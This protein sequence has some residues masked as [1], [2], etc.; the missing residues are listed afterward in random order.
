LDHFRYAGVN[1]VLMIAYHYPPVQGSSGIQRTLKFAQ[2]LPEFGWQPIV[3][4]VHPRAYRERNGSSLSEG[5]ETIVVHRTFGLDTTRHLAIHGRYPRLLALPDP[6]VSW[7]LGAVPAGLRLIRKYRPQV[8]WSTYP[9]ATA[10]V[11]GLT[12]ARLTRI[13]WIA[14][15]RDPMTDIDYPPDPT[16][17]M[18]YQ[19][20]ERRTVDRSR[21]S[22]CTTPSAIQMYRI[23]YPEVPAARFHVIPN[24]YDETEFK[25]VEQ[26]AITGN[27]EDRGVKPL[28][29]VHSGTLYPSERD[30]RQLFAALSELLEQGKICGDSLRIVL[31]ATGHDGYLRALIDE[32]RIG[33]VVMLAPPIP[34]SR[35]LLEMLRA[36][37]LL[38]LQAS[39]CNQQVPAKLYEYLRTRRPILALTDPEGDT[40]GVLRAAGIDTIARLDSK[41]A[42][43]KALMRFVTLL[44]SKQ[45]P[46]VETNQL[47]NYSRKA[48]T[49]ELAALFEDIRNAESYQT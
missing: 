31:R 48:R 12:L 49:A 16:T 19:W 9:V 28:V 20:I 42:I 23:K 13:P 34:Y 2:Y 35:A 4:T 24:G 43:I 22:V 15:F 46:I 44:R 30:P 18:V 32:A 26:L 7:W 6:W 8:L 1:R 11:I 25:K 21:C 39:N 36:D 29:L 10:H 37:G 17:K 38:I 5:S 27:P 3:L 33:A 47:A 45:A 14:D 41:D 40:A